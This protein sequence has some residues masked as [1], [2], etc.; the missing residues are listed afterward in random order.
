MLTS[1]G[2]CLCEAKKTAKV[3]LRCLVGIRHKV[4]YITSILP[5]HLFGILVDEAL[6]QIG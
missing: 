4:R 1:F 3:A 6:R 5:V 2:S